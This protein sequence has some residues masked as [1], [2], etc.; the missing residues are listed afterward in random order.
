MN[1]TY[2]SK[3]HNV[4]ATITPS[5]SRFVLRVNSTD[6]RSAAKVEDAIAE[7]IEYL[8]YAYPEDAPT[9]ICGARL[10][11]DGTCPEERELDARLLA[12]AQPMVDQPSF[13]HDDSYLRFMCERLEGYD[14]PI[15]DIIK[16]YA[17]KYDV[18]Y[19][20]ANSAFKDIF[21]WGLT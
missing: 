21:G 10:D 13:P 20:L 9:C 4:A 18:S 19:Q 6:G 15:R 16:D 1:I 17:D 11:A 5:G 12:E 7:L 3:G 14:V 8:L 2:T